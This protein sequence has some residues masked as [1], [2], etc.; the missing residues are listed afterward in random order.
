MD[1]PNDFNEDWSRFRD[2]L[3]PRLNP[4]AA[5]VDNS[6][7]DCVLTAIIYGMGPDMYNCMRPRRLAG[8]IWTWA[9]RL[10]SID[11]LNIAN[12]DKQ[13]TPQPVDWSIVKCAALMVYSGWTPPYDD[14][15]RNFSF[16]HILAADNHFNSNLEDTLWTTLTSD[17][18]RHP[19]VNPENPERQQNFL[20]SVFFCAI[21]MYEATEPM[22][23]IAW[24]PAI[25]ASYKNQS[26]PVI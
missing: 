2:V 3:N 24:D 8:P 19:Y 15:P 5:K 14:T 4:N 6:L 12:R 22:W 17:K 13:I 23:S 9:W 25:I 10:A 7:R 21:E 18:Y 16:E 26:G 20:D 11:W 1:T